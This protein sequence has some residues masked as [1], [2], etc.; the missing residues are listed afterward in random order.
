MSTGYGP[1]CLV[2]LMFLLSCLPLRGRPQWPLHAATP[3]IGADVA[4]AFPRG[5]R[6]TVPRR[7]VVDGR[8]IVLTLTGSRDSANCWSDDAAQGGGGGG[9]RSDPRFRAGV[10]YR[11]M[12]GE[13]RS[14]SDA[15][16]SSR[17]RMLCCGGTSSCV[18]SSH[19]SRCVSPS[20]SD[21]TTEELSART[22]SR[23]ADATDMCSSRHSSVLM[24]RAAAD[25]FRRPSPLVSHRTRHE[26]RDVPAGRGLPAISG[27][28]AH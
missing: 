5:L 12:A 3:R 23:S 13:W 6:V 10:F 8:R 17:E 7:V 15:G 26:H 25:N 4:E 11:Q 14:P 22:S 24:T 19:S 1:S 2:G 16:L 9:G 18:V 27:G 28:S 20:P 21:V